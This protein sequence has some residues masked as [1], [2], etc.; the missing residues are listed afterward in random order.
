MRMQQAGFPSMRPLR[1]PRVWLGAWALMI[2]AVI[3]LSLIPK[4]PIPQ[5]LVIGKLDHLI[6]YFALAAFAMQLYLRPR[7][8]LVAA[9]AMVLLGIALELAQ[10]YL[11]TYRHMAVYDALIDTLGVAL[12]TALAWTPLAGILLRIERVVTRAPR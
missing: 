12:G 11:T 5:P 9:F 1:W 7:A 2:V 10:G 6:A 4:P 8:Q 3:V